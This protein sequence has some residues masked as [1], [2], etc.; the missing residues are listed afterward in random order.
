MWVDHLEIGLITPGQFVTLKLAEGDH[1]VAGE[2]DGHFLATE[3]SSNTKVTLHDGEHYFMKLVVESKA[4]AGIG[5]T[6]WIAQRVSCEE[7]NQEAA[8]SG[9]VKLKRIEKTSL[10]YVDRE[11]YFPDCGK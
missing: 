2:A 5:K 7:A 1:V 4:V 10:E 8:A 9:P 3:S 11:S 6:H